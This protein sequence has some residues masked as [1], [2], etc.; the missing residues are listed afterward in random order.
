MTKSS[1]ITISM[2]ILGICVIFYIQFLTPTL[3]GADGYLH[4]RMAEFLRDLGPRYDFHWA[5]YSTFSTHFSDKDFLF[6]LI[7]VPFTFFKDI[8]F[9]AKTAAALFASFLLLAYYLLLKKYV[10][11]SLVPFF[12]AI[13]FLSDM[14]L[15][16]IS[17]PRPISLVIL[18]TLVSIHLMIKKRYCLLFLLAVLYSLGHV[19][20]PLIILYAVIVEIVRYIEKKEFYSKNIIAAF[21][22]VLIGFLI[23][24]D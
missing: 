10:H 16:T 1:L 12:L 23:H 22:G 7:L 19:T 9:G 3:Y 11:K 17:R 15:E 14:F 5:R 21:S 13:F 6:H 18:V 20:S 24:P 2:L 8:F 4:I